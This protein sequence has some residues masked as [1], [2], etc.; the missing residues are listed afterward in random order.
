[1]AASNE[2]KQEADQRSKD[3][4]SAQQ[5]MA[6]AAWTQAVLGIVTAVLLALTLW[7]T[8]RAV[9]EAR[10]TTRAATVA[11][12]A[13]EEQVRISRETLVAEQRAWLFVDFSVISGF[14][15]LDDR[16]EIDVAVKITNRGKSPALGVRTTMKLVP[17]RQLY[18]TSEETF[19]QEAKTA[20]DLYPRGVAGETDRLY[21]DI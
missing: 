1:L 10:N 3:D 11:A 18:D 19:F 20:Y 14:R 17:S 4:L 5:S 6:L 2:R 16:I 8:R 15:I 12:Q 7:F 21:L 9:I 13:A